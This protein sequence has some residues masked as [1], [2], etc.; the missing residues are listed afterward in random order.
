MTFSKP[1]F[2]GFWATLYVENGMR[3]GGFTLVAE[4][5]LWPGKDPSPPLPIFH[6]CIILS[7]AIL[8]AGTWLVPEIH[9]GES[10]Q[11]HGKESVQGISIRPFPGLVN[12]V[13]AVA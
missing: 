4:C 8:G 12:F 11:G 2:R 13:P 5:E 6:Y 9:N 10:G 7:P 3:K 1:A